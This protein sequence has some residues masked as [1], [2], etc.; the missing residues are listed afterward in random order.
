M[1]ATEERRVVTAAAAARRR[2][3]RVDGHGRKGQQI[4]LEL[5]T[6][7]PLCAAALTRGLA[8]SWATAVEWPCCV[9]RERAHLIT[10]GSCGGRCRG[11]ATAGWEVGR[12]GQAVEAPAPPCG[13]LRRF[14]NPVTLSEMALARPRNQL[15]NTLRF[16]S[17][18]I[19]GTDLV[20]PTTS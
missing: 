20:N 6:Q 1:R 10:S 11:L 8:V 9:G 4:R 18:S 16:E 2:S 19:R 15:A 13:R 12:L 7:P 14:M 17:D 3:K 5:A